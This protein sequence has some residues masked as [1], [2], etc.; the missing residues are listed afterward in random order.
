M[1]RN[2]EKPII[3]VVDDEIE[4]RELVVSALTSRLPQASIMGANSGNQAISILK[5]YPI[6]VIVSD[7]AMPDGNGGAL[8]QYRNIHHSGVPFILA[9]AYE[10]DALPEFATLK[11]SAV[12]TK[13]FQ[14]KEL[15]SAVNQ[16]LGAADKSISEIKPNDAPD[17][18][19]FGVPTLT[20]LK[21]GLLNSDVYI[22]ISDTKYLKLFR[23]QFLRR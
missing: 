15:I 9:T 19:Y 14:I 12:V 11:P 18:I 22:K 5:Q 3:L 13:P 1:A 17:V 8:F 4:L 6:A 20:L 23:H 7:Y 10:V 21:T 16:L 2:E